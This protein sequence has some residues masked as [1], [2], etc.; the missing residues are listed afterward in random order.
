MGDRRMKKLLGAAIAAAALCSAPAFAADMPVKAPDASVFNWTGFYVGVNAGHSFGDSN[1][2]HVSGF[3][4]PTGTFGLGA[5]IAAGATPVTA[6]KS[7]GFLGGGLAG[8]NWQVAPSWIFGVETD[9]T[10]GNVRGSETV[11]AQPV[12]FVLNVTTPTQKLDWLG[13]TRARLGYAAGNVLFYGTGGLAYGQVKNS[14]N[15]TLPASG[16]SLLGSDSSDQVGWAAGGGIEY[17]LGSWRLRA[18]YIH[19]DLGSHTITTN[20]VVNFASPASLSVTQ[21]EV[22]DLVRGAVSYRF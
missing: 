21:K 22:G 10:G 7:S 3:S 16:T 15:L 20:T 13:T 19:Y 9:F 11:A 1:G 2:A 5:A 8:Y 17:G 4:D 18:E 14:L 12:G 6:Y